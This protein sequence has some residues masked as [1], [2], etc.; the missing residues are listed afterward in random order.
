MVA[1]GARSIYVLYPDALEARFRYSKI[2]ARD[3]TDEET[4]A[5]VIGMKRA[6]ISKD[7]LYF[8]GDSTVE[9]VNWPV[10]VNGEAVLVTGVFNSQE[11]V[12]RYVQDRLEGGATL[13]EKP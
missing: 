3:M 1:F 8:L 5:R 9:L 4:K 6:G 2:G 11:Q 7:E 12:A 13:G 10:P